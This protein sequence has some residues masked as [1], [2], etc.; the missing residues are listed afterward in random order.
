MSASDKKKLRK[1][2]A[3]AVLSEKQRQEQAEAKKLKLYTMGFIAIMVAIV[4]IAVG[5]LG[6]RAVTQSGVFE[7]NTIAAVIGDQEINSVEMSY[8]YSDAISEFYNEWYEQYDSYTDS[9][10]QMM[11]LDTTQPMDT[12]IYDAETGETWADYFVAT[13]LKNAKSD[14]ALY[15]KAMADSE[16]SLSEEEKTTLDNMISSLETYA[17]LY[18]FNSADKY[19]A[20]MYGYGS[21]VESYRLYSERS[22][23][24]N[25]YLTYHGESLTYEDA[26]LREYEKD[27]MDN[28]NSYTY[29]AAYLSYTD[30]R[31]GGVEEDDG[32]VTYS[33]EENN[34]GR[35]ALRVA[36]EQLATCKTLEEIEAML[37]T[38]EVSEESEL[39]VGAYTNKMHT[40]LNADLSTWL[41]AEDRTSGEIA[42]VP[43]T[44]TTT[45]EDGTETSVVNA[46]YIVLFESKS[47]NKQLMSNVRHLLVEF[48]GG[49][50]DEETLEI[51]YSDEEKNAAKTEAEGYL[52]QWKEGA[53]DEASFIEL[54]KEYSDDSSAADGGLF[55]NI[56]PGSE[57]VENFLN[58]SIDPSRQVGDC[59]VIESEYGYHVMYFVGNSEQN[60]RDYMIENELRAEDHQA[61]YDALLEQVEATVKDTS[62]MNLDIALSAG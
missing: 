11:G 38:F 19:L 53:A 21:D 32:T 22:T 9:Y 5:V 55:E 56:N 8:Y 30:F 10:L 18:G 20:A 47:D 27:K 23:I 51:T 44:S 62:R 14:Y 7:K 13:A 39:E 60:Y 54:V 40:T 58:W 41:A 43:V 25:A 16:F 49:T 46:Y 45:A 36:A 33:E 6:Y 1:E 59:E 3:A 4:G 26:D 12:Q 35:E 17:Q 57:Y 34:A 52:Q 37:P 15:N 48:E 31:K 50:E 2:Q 24:A 28:Y 61:W 42:A 29:H